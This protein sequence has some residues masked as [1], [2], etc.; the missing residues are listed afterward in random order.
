MG[1]EKKKESVAKMDWGVALIGPDVLFDID[2]H[3][4]H[5]LLLVPPT[6]EVCRRAVWAR[7]KKL[8]RG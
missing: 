7:D 2:V 1:E 8:C 6:F 3:T 5:T 4:H